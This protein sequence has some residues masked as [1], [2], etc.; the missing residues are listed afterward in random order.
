MKAYARKFPIS[1]RVYKQIK[2]G[3][4]EWRVENCSISKTHEG[5]ATGR[6][7]VSALVLSK[8]LEEMNGFKI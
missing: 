3:R 2:R 5:V 1:A 7:G 6:L 4:R 8:A